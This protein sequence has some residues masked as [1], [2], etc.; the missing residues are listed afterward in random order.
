VCRKGS[1]REPVASPNCTEEDVGLGLEEKEEVQQEVAVEVD[2]MYSKM[3]KYML[4]LTCR[5]FAGWDAEWVQAKMGRTYLTKKRAAGLSRMCFSSWCCVF[6]TFTDQTTL[7]E[8]NGSVTLDIITR[9]DSLNMRHGFRTARS[10][11]YWLFRNTSVAACHLDTSDSGGSLWWRL[12]G[13]VC[14]VGR[15]ARGS[16][17]FTLLPLPGPDSYDN[18]DTDD[19]AGTIAAHPRAPD[20]PCR[21]KAPDSGCGYWTLPVSFRPRDRYDCS[22]PT[23]TR[24]AVQATSATQS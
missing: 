8:M 17:T 2:S 21:A 1:L 7:D 16:G 15:V 24:L 20:L 13:V 5:E 14:I 23:R 18:P 19:E 22:S 10:A 11:V 9:A 3:C 4:P 6:V 12:H